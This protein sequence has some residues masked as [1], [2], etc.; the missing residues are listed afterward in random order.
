[1]TVRRGLT[2]VLALSFFIAA[3]LVATFPRAIHE[4]VVWQ[5]LSTGP[6]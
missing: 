4:L 2:T 5:R 1:L 6:K 3:A